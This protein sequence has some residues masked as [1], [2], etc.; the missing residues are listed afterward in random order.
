[1][2]QRVHGRNLPL[3][4]LSRSPPPDRA[5]PP[6][7][8]NCGSTSA[9]HHANGQPANG[10]SPLP[11]PA[12][13]RAD[14]PPHP[15]PD[16]PVSPDPAARYPV[17]PLAATSEQYLVVP[18]ALRAVDLLDFLAEA[19]P[20]LHHQTLRQWLAAGDIRVNGV[21]VLHTV[22]VRAGDVV[23]VPTDRTDQRPAPAVAHQT[24]PRGLPPV[25][26]ESPSALVLA[27]PAGVPVVP[28]R[29]GADRGLHGQFE[30]LRPG[31]DL[32][33]VH[34][35]DRDTSGCLLL[36]KGLAAAQH[37]DAQFQN[38]AVHK[39]YLALVLGVPSEARFAIDAWLGPDPRRPGKVVASAS[40]RRGY[41]SAH[42]DVEVLES[43]GRAALCAVLPRT[44]RSHQIRVHLQSV[45]HPIYGDRDYGGPELLLSEWKPGYKL[46][47]GV[48]ERPVLA[49][50]FLHSQRLAAQDLDGQP[51]AVEAPLPEDLERALAL[52][53]RH[54]TRRR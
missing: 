31:A 43:F 18:D 32:R 1:M 29:S 51:F 41:R 30:A 17:R 37:F 54:G 2:P 5:H 21:E 50:L 39:T 19:R 52:L 22:R 24:T 34:R 26:W 35:L 36:A 47:P 53:R 25:L 27:K 11:T 23:E 4:E 16:Q 12:P 46:R 7:S 40:E 48:A 20:T 44:G 9:R 6:A 45:G 14:R 49:R 13:H 42:S 28:D 33:V 10:K 8:A 3:L 38:Q 15:T